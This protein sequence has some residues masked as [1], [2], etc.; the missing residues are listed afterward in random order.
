M[1]ADQIKDNKEISLNDERTE[2]K[3][4]AKATSSNDV[5][6]TTKKLSQ[7][8][9]AEIN[10]HSDAAAQQ[11]VHQ[12]QPVASSSSAIPEKGLLGSK[13]GYD[14]GE[15]L[16]GREPDR[17]ARLQQRMKAVKAQAEA[18]EGIE[19]ILEP[20]KGPKVHMWP[21]PVS[22]PSTSKF[23]TSL[24][25]NSKPPFGGSAEITS[26]KTSIFSVPDSD[27]SSESSSG[28]SPILE[29]I[30]NLNPF[31]SKTPPATPEESGS[32]LPNTS[33]DSDSDTEKTGQTTPI[34]SSS[35]SDST[36]KESA[37]LLPQASTKQVITSWL[38]PNE[39]NSNNTF[40]LVNDSQIPTNALNSFNVPLY[41]ETQGHKK[42]LMTTADG[43]S[44]IALYH[45]K[46]KALRIYR[47]GHWVEAVTS[48]DPFFLTIQE[49][50][51]KSSFQ[52]RGR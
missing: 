15:S 18:S 24:F 16:S 9:L 5:T 21:T 36:V 23:K 37:P 13:L 3:G 51:K 40:K 7:E 4:K 19:H 44:E 30:K 28:R 41:M 39:I 31:Q 42:V 43:N 1:D 35:S 33:Y 32:V 12:S 25:N 48:D 52:G 27:T 47:A 49:E 17:L 50:I 26:T 10:P 11:R 20:Q 38:Y 46:N 8:D 6:N 2:S 45:A 14:Q 34:N 22:E 29:Q